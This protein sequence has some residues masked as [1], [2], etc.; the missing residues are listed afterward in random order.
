MEN[1][2]EKA[3]ENT[4]EKALEDM[5][6][7]MEH[8]NEML[9][10][11]GQAKLQYEYN[12]LDESPLYWELYTKFRE[13]EAA[14][15]VAKKVTADVTNIANKIA[16]DLGEEAEKEY[17]ANLKCPFCGEIGSV[18]GGDHKKLREAEVEYYKNLKCTFCGELDSVCGGDH[19][20]EMRWD[21]Q[22]R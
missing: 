10:Q 19:S 3:T 4:M 1:T 11:Y 17:F 9:H 7:A 21:A 16:N 18:C 5:F 15:E 14:Y 8:E 22:N 13:A 20:F 6:T 12:K 2:T